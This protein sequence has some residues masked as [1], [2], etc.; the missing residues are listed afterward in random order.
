ML[1]VE[2]LSGGVILRVVAM[3]ASDIAMLHRLNTAVRVAA[4]LLIAIPLLAIEADARPLG[5]GGGGGVKVGGGGGG[6]GGG[7][8]IG[9]APRIGGGGGV[10]VRSFSAPR[11][12]GS[13]F[14]VRS[15]GGGGGNRFVG[16]SLA[17][18]S[19][20][21]A[22][23]FLNAGPGNRFTTASAHT[24]AGPGNFARAGNL[25]RVHAAL[26]HR[27]IA[28]KALIGN[29][30]RSAFGLARF[31]G[32]F[33]GSHWPWWRGGIVIG[34]VGPVFWPYASY[35]FF[36]Y[37]FWPYAYDDF[38]PYAFDDVYYGIY[39]G[40]AYPGPTVGPVLGSPRPRAGSPGRGGG[41]AARPSGVCSDETS[42]LTDWPIERIAEVVQPTDAQGA[43][44]DALKAAN[45][46]A[47]D[48]LK[49]ACPKELPSI[50]T[51][52][53][54][55][56]Q[57]RLEVMLQAVQT[58]RPA[59]EQLYQSL[60]NE[61]K[62]R[63]NAIMPA[64]EASAGKDRR[65]LATFCDARAPGVTDLPIDRI[66]QVVQP[67]P[68]QQAGLDELKDAS[69]KAAEGLKADCPSY[70]TLTPTGRIEAME[71]RLSAMLAA[72]KT[73]QPALARFYDALSDEQKARFNA[74]RST[75]K[76]VG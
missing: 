25:A 21:N 11:I 17:P 43:L 70:Q 62:A 12:G 49:G 30:Q 19:Q 18:S 58:I 7:R 1:D 72:V 33:H 44:L 22:G 66:A 73:V 34:W 54:A 52:R 20:V 71:Q 40:F 10:G 2:Q 68:E 5:G 57:T 14:A 28:N 29:A 42:K 35:D 53:L 9:V 59:L 4:S 13:S 69:L 24:F 39:G 26:G 60:D 6:Y 74:M 41:A 65:D 76:P 32:R 27:V 31:Q 3:S 16:R 61:Q 67:T 46:K 56:M 23:R 64:N 47:I 8:G 45:A 75:G 48:I 15:L 50:P 55:A 51:G 63:F 37:V 38:W 36:D